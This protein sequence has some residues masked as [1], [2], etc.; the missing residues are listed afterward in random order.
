LAQQVETAF[1]R[2]VVMG[3]AIFAF[4][5]PAPLRAASVHA[6]IVITAQQIALHSDR[7]LLIADGGVAVHGSQFQLTA[8]RAEYDL[9]AN[10]LIAVGDVSVADGSSRVTTAGY[11]YDFTAKHGAVSK[12]ATVPQLST[13]DALAVGQQVE[14]QPAGSMT[15][16]NA[17]VQAGAAF[18]PMASYTYTIPPPKS[19]NWGS[20]PVPSAALEWPVLVG[21]S[22]DDYEF[23]RF[24]YDRYNGGGGLGLEEHYA[25]NNGYVAVGETLDADGSRYDLSAYQQLSPSL[26]E[27]LGSSYLLGTH[28][29]RYALTS[30]G[31]YGYASLSSSQYDADR[32][33]DLL[34]TSTQHPL[35]H[36]ASFRF[37]A[38]LGHDIHPGNA[39]V[40]QDFRLTPDLHIDTAT[41]HMGTAT[42]SASGDAGETMYNYGR[43]T[44][45]T[46]GT[47][48]GNFPMTGRLL[49]NGGASFSHDAPP[50]PSTTRTYTLGATWRASDSFNLVS[51]LNY[52][53]DFD[54]TFNNGRPE[55]TAG[56]DIRV[57][58]KNGTGFEVGTLLP[59]GGVGNMY[60]QAVL[61]FRFIK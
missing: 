54:Q 39:P 53:H 46:D 26:S 58:R 50:F 24:R 7:G 44:L 48:W 56:L 13:Q 38:D 12:S 35:W 9:R 61:N 25:S 2:R 21:Y 15:F 52:A 59:F 60:R 20:S 4:L 8:T 42:V 6:P 33:D 23:A 1:M 29:W 40:A 32:S 27:S 14:L 37:Q 49:L 41:L 47:L 51:S 5:A 55:Y 34:V 31:R 57:K 18:T 45:A 3:L 43:G 16:S 22:Q 19:K 30:V 36:I 28:T 17:Q 11:V 10:V